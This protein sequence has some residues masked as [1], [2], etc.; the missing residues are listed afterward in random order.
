MKITRTSDWR[1]ALAFETP[2][3]ADTVMPGEPARCVT[4]GVETE[5]LPRTQLWAVKHR[6]PHDPAGSVRLYCAAHAPKAAAP[7]ASAAA[8][9]SAT[10][11]AHDRGTASA[12]RTPRAAAPRAHRAAVPKPVEKPDVVCPDCYMVVAPSGICGVCG[13]KVA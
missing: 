1:D 10:Q 8:A 9:A 2:M 7:V 12:P 5:P 11:S 4:C 3:I 6:H 13:Q